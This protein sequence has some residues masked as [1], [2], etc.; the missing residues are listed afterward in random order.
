MPVAVPVAP[1]PPV[2][3]T[4]TVAVA[5]ATPEVKGTLVAELAPVYW[6]SP[7]S[8][9]SSLGP[10]V[11]LEGLRTLSSFGQYGKGMKMEGGIFTCQ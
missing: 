11:A 8:S 2:P 10:A 5:V 3:L 7:L 1:P 9:F 4:P 6:T